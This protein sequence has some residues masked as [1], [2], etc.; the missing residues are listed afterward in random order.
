[1]EE[2]FT[3]LLPSGKRNQVFVEAVECENDPG[4]LN[5]HSGLTDSW[6]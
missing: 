3:H 2:L 5:V 1:M 4:D 6:H